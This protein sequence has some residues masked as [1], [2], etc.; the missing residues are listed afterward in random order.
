MGDQYINCSILH[1]TSSQ[2][3]R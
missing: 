1:I 2:W 3:G